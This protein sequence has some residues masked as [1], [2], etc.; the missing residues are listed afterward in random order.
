MIHQIFVRKSLYDSKSEYE[1]HDRVQSIVNYVNTLIADGY[2]NY[3]E[4]PDVARH[5]YF[6]D[7]VMAEVLNGGFEQFFYNSGGKFNEDV[8]RGLTA[9]GANEYA[10][11]FKAAQKLLESDPS[12]DNP[13]L[14]KLNDKFFELDEKKALTQFCD[15][16]LLK[17]QSELAILEDEHYEASMNSLTKNDPNINRRFERS[18]AELAA[19]EAENETVRFWE[20]SC[21]AF[22]QERGLEYL[23]LNCFEDVAIGGEQIP[24]VFFTGGNEEDPLKLFAA[25]SQGE[26]VLFIDGETLQEIAQLESKQRGL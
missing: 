15:A 9:V 14:D 19:I 22:C 5:V 1:L 17:H 7:Y 25:Y 3:E 21:E 16:Y 20:E 2:W 26:K 24:A 6:T 13:K 10:K 11:I 8:I 18:K 4:I 23:G 12:E